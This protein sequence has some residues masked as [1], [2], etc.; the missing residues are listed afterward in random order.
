M[1]EEEGRFKNTASAKAEKSSAYK[2][3]L[4]ERKRGVLLELRVICAANLFLAGR[5][6]TMTERMGVIRGVQWE[7]KRRRESRSSS[8]GKDAQLPLQ[9]ISKRLLGR[10]C[11]RGC[12]KKRLFSGPRFGGKADLIDRT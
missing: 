7:K 10:S 11:I 3:L 5:G 8:L 9:N 12:K 2:G 4:K 1:T 6:G